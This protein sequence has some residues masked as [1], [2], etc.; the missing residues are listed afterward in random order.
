MSL[1]AAAITPVLPVGVPASKAPAGSVPQ[2]PAISQ[3]KP[4]QPEPKAPGKVIAAAEKPAGVSTDPKM[5]P[6][7]LTAGLLFTGTDKTS[8]MSKF[9]KGLIG[10]GVIAAAVKAFQAIRR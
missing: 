10:I 1:A 5:N 3:P 6:E 9:T 8:L 2:T 4:T 7:V